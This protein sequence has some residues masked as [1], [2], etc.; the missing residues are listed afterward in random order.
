MNNYPDERNASVNFNEK[1]I[2]TL[3]CVNTIDLFCISIPDL[4]KPHFSLFLFFHQ[5]CLTLIFA[6]R[7]FVC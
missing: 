2:K 4:S 6:T 3:Q 5:F 7:N 1:I